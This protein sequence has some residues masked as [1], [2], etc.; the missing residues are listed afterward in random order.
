MVS[1]NQITPSNNTGT[2]NV[3][4][5]GGDDFHHNAIGGGGYINLFGG[6]I[7]FIGNTNGDLFENQSTGRFRN[8]GHVEI[9]L[10]FTFLNLG[11][12]ELRNTGSN[13]GTVLINGVFESGGT[14]CGTPCEVSLGHTTTFTNA[15]DFYNRSNST[16]Y[17][18]G[19]FVSTGTIY[20]EGNWQFQSSGSLDLNGLFVN[21]AGAALLAP[22]EFKV[23]AG[24]GLRIEG[25]TAD[26]GILDIQ[27]G[28]LAILDG[29]LTVT[30]HIKKN[31]GSFSVNHASGSPTL[32]LDRTGRAAGTALDLGG[33]T[34]DLTV[35]SGGTGRLE[36]RGGAIVKNRS[37]YIGNDAGSDGSILVD[38]VG[39]R[40]ESKNAV[41]VG[42]YGRGE[43]TIQNGGV[44]DIGDSTGDWLA[45]GDYASGV[46]KATVDGAGSLLR[47][48]GRLYVGWDATGTLGVESGGFL[49]I[50]NGGEVCNGDYSGG[51]AGTGTSASHIGFLNGSRGKVVI[52]GPGSKWDAGEGEFSVGYQGYGEL[53]IT[54]GGRLETKNAQIVR[55]SA[56]A[57]G[58]AIVDGVGHDGANWVRSM[59]INSSDDGNAYFEVGHG[60]T[61]FGD[62]SKLVVSNG[63]LVDT[64]G[65]RTDLA[66]DVSNRNTRVEVAGIHE[67][68]G[69][70]AEWRTS[71][72]TV[73]YGG[74]ASLIIR[75]GGLVTSQTVTH[76]NGAVVVGQPDGDTN[77]NTSEWR[78][79]DLYVGG[80]ARGTPSYLTVRTHGVL[81]AS[82]GTVDFSNGGRLRI[83]GGTLRA[84]N[85]IGDGSDF[86]WTSG[87]VEL[88]SDFDYG[89]R[90]L[91][92][93]T[94]LEESSSPSTLNLTE[95]RHLRVNGELKL[96]GFVAGHHVRM[97]VNEGSLTVG[98]LDLENPS[99][100]FR[101]GVGTTL[102]FI[103]ASA[104]PVVM[105]PNGGVVRVNGGLANLTFTADWEGN[106]NQFGV[107]NNGQATIEKGPGSGLAFN[108]GANISVDE[109]SSLTVSDG[110]S[111]GT[112]SGG[113]HLSVTTGGTLHGPSIVVGSGNGGAT[114]TALV[115]GSKSEN[116]TVSYSSI[117]STGSIYVGLNGKGELTITN[118]ASADAA[119]SIQVGVDGLLNNASGIVNGD[120]SSAGVV[121]GGGI[122]NGAFN[123]L[124]GNTAPGNSPG[125]MTINGD[126]NQDGA[127]TLEIELGGLIP[128]TEYDVLDVNGTATLAGTLDVVAYDLGGGLFAPQLG[129]SFDVIVADTI[130]GSFDSTTLF[131][132]GTGLQWQVD[133][134]HDALNYDVLR[135]S[136]AAVPL[137]AGVWMMLPGL[138]G[139]VMVQR[140]RSEASI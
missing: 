26:I 41:A 109:K 36:I 60:W 62:K 99:D 88:N 120:V 45:I 84:S 75:N 10:G 131:A 66:V 52:D 20:N 76:R 28:V 1:A 56:S 55:S 63:A 2:L 73:G 123:V 34:G 64:Q 80:S 13:Q 6:T 112:Q 51:C 46:G 16:T 134:I 42:R 104:N 136:V 106:G 89:A 58:I 39:S 9:D 121:T 103:G 67:P 119:H 95:G 50:K 135:L 93:D 40:W 107:T 32:V 97:I 78:L 133:Y 71:D 86:D 110:L 44:V 113:G 49:E 3:D 74:S 30:D 43:L 94:P 117:T 87:T 33:S 27:S 114:A 17:L 65:Q 85:L 111:L 90:L 57:G 140:R 101:T 125:L 53:E 130:S 59:W 25:G 22:D 122:F 61:E 116:G 31:A 128:G 11:D 21:R 70:R 102:E 68:S 54:G 132:L 8:F 77:I 96:G 14:G 92:G 5:V 100:L 24:G 98:S 126:Y 19:D 137:P 47:H 115:D 4:N 124:G 18:N 23:N 79:D 81:D 15:G 91:A 38:G 69:F 138:V 139:L 118:G 7:N 72:L 83:W 127:S 82:G 35:G 29:T 129:D 108:R 48:Q 12:F 37:G 105:E